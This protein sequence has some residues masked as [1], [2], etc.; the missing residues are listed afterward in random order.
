[1]KKKFL[2]LMLLA[3]A[4]GSYFLQAQKPHHHLAQEPPRIPFGKRLPPPDVRAGEE[5]SYFERR[6]N[7]KKGRR[8]KEDITSSLFDSVSKTDKTYGPK[9]DNYDSWSWQQNQKNERKQK[10]GITGFQL[11]KDINLASSS[12]PRNYTSIYPNTFAIGSN[13]SYFAADDGIHGREIW[14]SDGTAAGTYLFRDVNPGEAGSNPYEISF[15][16]NKLFFAASDAAHGEELWVSDGTDAGTIRLTDVAPGPIGGGPNQLVKIGS[17]V[18]FMANAGGYHSPQLWKTDGTTQGTQLVY[19]FRS[20]GSFDNIYQCT[21]ANGLL[22]F[23]A[24]NFNANAKLWRSDGTYEGTFP[25]RNFGNNNYY[26]G[27][28]QLTEYNN[29]LYFSGDD[30]TGNKLWISDGT[31]EGTVY[32]PGHNNITLASNNISVMSATP[33]V[34]HDN[35]LYLSGYTTATGGGLYKYDASNANGVELVKDISIGSD[36]S[37]IPQGYMRF[38]EDVLYFKVLSSTGEYHEELWRSD[39]TTAN[40][41]MIKQLLPGEAAFDFTG[42]NRNL[43]FTKYDLQYGTELWTTDGSSAG[44]TLVKDIMQGPEASN[45]SM[46]S[47][48]NGKVIFN[49]RN[50]DGAELWTTNGTEAGTY[51]LK[52]INIHATED[53]SPGGFYWNDMAPLGK[54]LFFGAYTPRL[55]REL[56]QSDGTKSGTSLVKDI[57]T[58]LRKSAICRWFLTTKKHVYFYLWTYEPGYKNLEGIYKTDG[59]DKGTA[60]VA[61]LNTGALVSYNVADN[62]IVYYITYD[63]NTSGYTLFRSDG[64]EA[65]M[66]HLADNLYY[67]LAVVIKN[68]DAYFIAGTTETGY[69]LWKSDGSKAGTKMVKDIY[70][71]APSSYPYSLFEY[72]GNIYFGA[73]DGVA[74]YATF[75]KTDG[76]EKG[77]VKV[78]ELAPGYNSLF[79]ENSYAFSVLNNTLYFAAFDHNSSPYLGYQLWKTDGT[80]AGTKLVK[81]INPQATA[82]PQHMVNVD[83]QLFFIAYDQSNKYNLWVS[84]GT[85]AGTRLVKDIGPGE[86]WYDISRLVTAGGLLFFLKNRYR[87]NPQLWSSDGT[88]ENTQPV[89]LDK[90]TYI[91]NIAS[92]KNKIFVM[93]YSYQYG[94]ELYASDVKE[95]AQRRNSVELREIPQLITDAPFALKLFPNPAKSVATVLLNEKKANVSITITDISGKTVWQRGYV[96][97]NRISLPM[98]QLST[99]LYTVTVKDALTTK[100]IKLVKQ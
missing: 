76:T 75:W 52:D 73:Y 64:T 27:V 68:N 35:Q 71:G 79:Y 7:E 72:K 48:V 9:K 16:N 98:D 31:I 18:F 55:G 51:I 26:R 3:I 70:V 83:K 78:K 90:I 50:D 86:D 39:G 36:F 54:S 94:H 81:N 33:F 49:A 8:E 46:F 6:E 43:L 65:G 53:G 21:K 22:F 2:L 15:V 82:N 13:I 61:D 91:S 47:I 14:R 44:T 93:G 95:N 19:D 74:P 37:A 57:N 5:R 63:Y 12:E 96:S 41:S 23:T 69:E 56:F 66:Y 60:K 85:N 29:R 34:K 59:T 89:A 11:T 58:A 24:T 77:T 92:A 45:P 42:Y 88:A 40:T 87:G 25:L 62:G 4:C 38:A 20:N 84:D 17:S 100:T 30:G 99:G 32:A 28:L 67:N 80:S 10:N 97:V 1:M